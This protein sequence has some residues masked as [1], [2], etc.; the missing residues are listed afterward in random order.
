MPVELGS[1]DAIIALARAPIDSTSEMKD[2]SSEQLKD[3]PI[4]LYKTQ[5]LTLGISRSCL[6]RR[7]MDHSGCALTIGN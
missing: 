3:C 7:R 4:K 2:L 5:F 6:S 1:F